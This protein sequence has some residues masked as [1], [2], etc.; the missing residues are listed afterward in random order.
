MSDSWSVKK[1]RKTMGGRTTLDGVIDDMGMEREEQVFER[2]GEFT[3]Q[4]VVIVDKLRDV[5]ERFV[6]DRYRGTRGVGL[7]AGPSSRA[8]PTTPRRRSSTACPWAGCSSWTGPTSRVWWARWT[9]SPT[10]P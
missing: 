1:I 6:A 4:V 5:V 10:T 7:G 8:G 3:D 2:L 9:A